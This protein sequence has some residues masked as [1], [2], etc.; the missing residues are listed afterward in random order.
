MY[1]ASE[2]F[3]ELALIWSFSASNFWKLRNS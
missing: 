3:C 2:I 1:C